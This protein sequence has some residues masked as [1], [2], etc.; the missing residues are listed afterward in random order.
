MEKGMAWLSGR[1][2]PNKHYI[3]FLPGFNRA[4]ILYYIGENLELRKTEFAQQITGLTGKSLELSTSEVDK[5]I[6]RLFYWA[7]FADKYGGEVQ[8]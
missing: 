8:V 3:Y 6:A 7:A 4:Q 1:W 5:S 2:L